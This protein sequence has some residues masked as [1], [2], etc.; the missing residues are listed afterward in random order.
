MTCI[1]GMIDGKTVTI[2][3]DSAGVS[4]LDIIIRKDPKVFQTGEFLIGCTSSFRMIELLQFSLKVN[5]RKDKEVYEYMCTD[6]I[7]AVRKCFKKGGYLQKYNTGDDKGGL[8]LVGYEGRLFEIME[9]FQVA[10]SMDN[11]TSIGCGEKYAM[12]SLY[13]TEPIRSHKTYTIENRIMIALQ[14]ADKFSAGVCPP[15]IIK[16]LEKIRI[17][18]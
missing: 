10:E 4:G 3:A 1:I 2:G 17:T 11:Y 18:K 15:F 16:T 6:F 8:F 14:T 13:N 12:G 9:D 7:N 5:P